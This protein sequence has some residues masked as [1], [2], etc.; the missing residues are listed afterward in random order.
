MLESLGARARQSGG[1]SGEAIYRMVAGELLQRMPLGP[2][3]VDVG[4][5]GGALWSYVNSLCKQYIGIDAVRFDGFPPGGIQVIADLDAP[6]LPLRDSSCDVIVA[7]E[8]IEH[9][10]NPRA[11]VR[12]LLRAVRAGGVIMVTTPN[13]LSL[14][15]LLTLLVRHRFAAFQ[16]CDYPAHH[17]ALLEVDLR[18]LAAECDLQDVAVTYSGNGRIPKSSRPYPRFVSSRW[19]QAFSDNVLLAGRRR[20]T[21]A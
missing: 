16:D 2:T 1:H 4:C 10:E 3:L 18:R 20:S 19:P 5:G 13:Q 15:S 12:A 6:D 11:F 17:T 8:V 14:L 9:L 21:L 7:V